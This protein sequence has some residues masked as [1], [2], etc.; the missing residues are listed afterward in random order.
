MPERMKLSLFLI[1]FVGALISSPV[2]AIHLQDVYDD[3]G[4]GERYDKLLILDPGEIYTGYLGV[5]PNTS[6]AIHGNGALILLDPWGS[7]SASGQAKL[8]IDGCVI[9]GGTTGINYE[10]GSNSRVENCTI[11]NNT[12][13]IQCSETNV[14]ISNCIITNNSRFGIAHRGGPEP[15]ILYNN[16]WNNTSLNYA[17]F[18]PG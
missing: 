6:C 12:M 16:V 10:K 7:I 8:D 9:S 17:T 13:G 11:V 14:T 3:A 2:L 4:P 18:C 5:T 1:P 15:T